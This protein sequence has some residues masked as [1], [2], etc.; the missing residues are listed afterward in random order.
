[1]SV[2]SAGESVELYVQIGAKLGGHRE[3]SVHPSSKA[4]YFFFSD[5]E[6]NVTS[7]W[8]IW[9]IL[10]NRKSKIII[11]HNPPTQREA[12]LASWHITSQFCFI[13]FFLYD[14]SLNITDIIL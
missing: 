14:F 7:L 2:E 4:R 10:R 8:N 3:L 6:S 1:M 13:L 12:L 5:I 11:T 9:K